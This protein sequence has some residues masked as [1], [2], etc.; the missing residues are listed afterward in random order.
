MFLMWVSILSIK[1]CI[2]AITSLFV[3][4]NCLWICYSFYLISRYFQLCLIL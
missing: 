4:I 2:E 1:K 3:V